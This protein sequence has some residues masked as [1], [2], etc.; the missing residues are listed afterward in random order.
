MLNVPYHIYAEFYQVGVFSKGCIL[1][2][3]I[4]PSEFWKEVQF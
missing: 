2:I 3:T 4:F 1:H